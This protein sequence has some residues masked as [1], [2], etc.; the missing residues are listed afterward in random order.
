MNATASPSRAA[1][2]HRIHVPCLSCGAVNRLPVARR[3]EGPRCAKCGH[4]LLDGGVFALDDERFDAFAGRL[5]LPLLVQFWAPWSAAGKSALP[6]LAA[7]ASQ[8]HGE[9]LVAR[10]S[11]NAGLK[12]MSRWNITA[13]PTLLWFDHGREVKRTTQ[14]LAAAQMV[15]WLGSRE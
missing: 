7:V 11:A 1:P 4:P 8:L 15:R 9:V 13:V 2:G 10:I 6:E 14:M 5:D 3:R 12:L